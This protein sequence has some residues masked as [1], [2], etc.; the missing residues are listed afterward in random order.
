[1]KKTREMVAIVG[2]GSVGASYF[3][4]LVSQAISRG[5]CNDFEVLLFEPQDT[6]GPGYAYQTD[7]D[8]NLLNTRADTMSAVANDKEHFLRWLLTHEKDWRSEY[9]DVLVEAGEFLPRGLFGRYLQSI[10]QEAMTAAAINGIPVTTVRDEV[11]DLLFLGSEQVCLDTRR[12]GAYIANRV[13]LC[14]GNLPSTN[15]REFNGQPGFFNSP[16]P[17]RRLT[18]EIPRDEAVCVLGANLSAI[19]AVLSLAQAGHRGKIVCVSRNGRLPS[20]RGACN[21]QHVLRN[22]TKSQIDALAAQH[23]GHLTLTAVGDLLR[24]EIEEATGTRIDLDSILNNKTGTYDYLSTEIQLSGQ[25]GRLWQSVIYA[26]NGIIDYVWHRLSPNDK[27]RFHECFRSLW[28]SYRVSFPLTN[29]VKVHELL[30]TDQLAIFGGFCGVEFDAKNE[31]FQVRL[32]DKRT[33]FRSL[34]ESRYII[35]ATS[36]SN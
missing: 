4:Q 6:S 13:I 34:V 5:Q 20:V 23:G 7:S 3:Y 2:G 18:D 29:A 12:S 14:I 33:G 9:P 30:R 16:Y 25:E 15:F 19:D 10:H 17:C 35:N 21:R 27:R 26:T 31:L 32:H 36:Y 22:I 11:V 1:M 28:M 8:C 24:K